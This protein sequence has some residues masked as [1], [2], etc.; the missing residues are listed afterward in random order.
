MQMPRLAPQPVELDNE[1]RQEL[2][3][4]LARHSTSQQVALRT[5]IRLLAPQGKNYRTIARE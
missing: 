5:K 2:A 1:D 3:K 4:I